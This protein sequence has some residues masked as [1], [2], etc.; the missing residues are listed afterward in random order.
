MNRSQR[1][2]YS[3]RRKP[4]PLRVMEGRQEAQGR[5]RQLRMAPNAPLTEGIDEDEGEQ[6][7]PCVL[8]RNR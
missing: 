6:A 7:I 2:A 1:E 8:E 5:K 3:R 4:M